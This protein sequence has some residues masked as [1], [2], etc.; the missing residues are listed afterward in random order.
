[1][2]DVAARLVE[3]LRDADGAI[4]GEELARRLG[5]SRAAVWKHMA[6]LRRQGYT[7]DASR[8]DGYRLAGVPDRLGPAELAPHFTGSW[9][10]VHYLDE[11]DSTQRVARD[12]ARAGAPEGT[13]VIAERQT[14]GRGRLG[15]QWHSPA[16]LNLY[17]SIVLRPPLPPVAVP[18]V[19]LV[20]G[21]A[22]A[23]AVAETTGRAPAIKWPNDVLV[24]G[25]KVAGILTEMDAEVERV[26]HVI[27]GIGVNLNAPRRAFPRELRD[28]AG[29]LLTVTGQRVDRAAFAARLLA[30]LEARYGRFLTAGFEAVR[31]EWESWSCLTGTEVSVATPDGDTTGRVVG[32]DADGAL[33]VERPDGSIARIV[34]GEVTL[35]DGYA[36][37]ARG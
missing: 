25:R 11:T 23:A 12:L 10:D 2:S 28:K 30:A 5:C 37:R 15:R 9:R 34:A 22:V 31:A 17:C 33:E 21:A 16:G 32:L 20:A 27:C 14:A 3:W 35:R 4:S 24:D 18:R 36:G 29:S 13:T 1:M 6:A 19:A 7:I 8:S 26:H